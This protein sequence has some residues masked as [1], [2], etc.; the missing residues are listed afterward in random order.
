MEKKTCK[1]YVARDKSGELCIYNTKPERDCVRDFWCSD[2]YFTIFPNLFPDLKWE[3]EPIEVELLQV[4][5]DIDTKAQEY[6]NKVTDNEEIKALI[7]NAYKA[8]YNE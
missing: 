8:G 6:A 2:L 3:D 5:T 7:I 4:I 1:L